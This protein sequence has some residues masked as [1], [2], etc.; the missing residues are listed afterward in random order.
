MVWATYIRLYVR[1]RLYLRSLRHAPEIG[2]PPFETVPID[3]AAVE[4]MTRDSSLPGRRK[5][6][7][8]GAVLDGE[9]D[10]QG[11]RFTDTDLYQAFEAHFEA[12][13]AWPETDFYDRIVREIEAG[14]D[15]WGCTSQAEFDARCDRLDRLYASM[16]EHGYVTQAELARGKVE[17]PIPNDRLSEVDQFIYDEMTVNV[18]RDGELLLGDGRDRLAIAKLLD[19]DEV[20]VQILVRHAQ[21]QRLLDA[22][23]QRPNGCEDLP[24][25]LVDHPDLRGYCTE[26]D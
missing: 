7:R 10:R 20:A 11:V 24:S 23:A 22:V 4:F 1:A 17:D 9:W 12:G 8:V 26:A 2:V 19:L 14:H 25:R 16:A 3:P 5:Y 13:E 18:G 21:W 6:K 15:R